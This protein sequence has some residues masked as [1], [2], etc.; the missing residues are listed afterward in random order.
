MLRP[1]LSFTLF[2]YTTLFRSELE[3]A[4]ARKVLAIHQ[5]A[6]L[7]AD[8]RR[9][10]RGCRAGQGQ[11]RR[12]AKIEVGC[13]FHKLNKQVSG[14]C[15]KNGTSPIIGKIGRLFQEQSAARSAPRVAPRVVS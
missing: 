15:K 6:A 4:S 10:L 3:L 9:N 12:G 11:E 2:P 8:G 5:Q 1:P 13:E 7:I 14:C